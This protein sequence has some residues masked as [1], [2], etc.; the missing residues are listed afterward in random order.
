M[1]ER[2]RLAPHLELIDVERSRTYQTPGE[3]VRFVCFPT[4]GLFSVLSTPMDG[5][6]V[7]VG[8]FG[9]EGFVGLFVV[10]G[11]EAQMLHVIGQVDRKA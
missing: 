2:A 10:L 11:D 6:T 4:T 8:A 9:C 7:E 3:P 5:R 1:A